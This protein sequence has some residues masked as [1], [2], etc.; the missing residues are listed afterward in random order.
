MLIGKKAFDFTAPAVLSDGS[1]IDDYNLYL[2]IKD[3]YCLLFFYPLDFTFVCPSELIAINNR[4]LEFK[5]RN[6]E[7]IAVSIDSKYVHKAWRDTL[8]DNGGIG[9]IGYTLISDVK[10]EIID[11]YDL[12]DFASGVSYRGVFIIDPSKVIRIFHVHDFQIGRNIDEYIRIIDA[13]IFNFKYGNVCQS[14]WKS[15]SDGIVPTKDGV[16]NYLK[17][18]YNKI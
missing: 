14:G 18:N 4:L 9:N 13:L 7:V 16:S 11:L 17:A 3:K 1:V 6:V 2:N 12:K 10:R 8:I 5:K 15:G